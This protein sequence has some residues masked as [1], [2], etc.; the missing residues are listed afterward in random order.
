VLLTISHISTYRYDA[1][2]AYAV[3]RVRLWPSSC[4]V[5]TVRDW[6]LD[7]TGA[8]PELTY[9]DAFGNRTELLRSTP[10][11]REITIHAKG[12][13]DTRDTAGVFG[14][15]GGV[16]PL[17][18]HQRQT[19]LTEPGEAIRALVEPLSGMSNQIDL[20]HRLSGEIT[21]RVAY[22]PDSTDVATPAE[23]ALTS[24][25]GVC[26]DYAHIFIAAA[27]LLGRPA[28]YVSGYLLIEGRTEQTATHA[29]AEAYVD[30]LGW[31]GFDAANGVSP[32]EKY[33]RIACGLDY[34]HAAPITGLRRGA[35]T[36]T[37][38]VTL[39]VE[40]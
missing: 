23:T 5:Q 17:W 27:R 30:D 35:S 21:A 40:Q 10:D 11:T 36:E 37:L 7:V 9:S 3:Q 31:V 13:V 20:L 15:G 19:E 8:A 12:Q 38:A 2:V 18:I 39:N 16:P 14:Q 1:P 25:S 4:A 22:V 32:D 6:R 28:R 29:W 26:Q 33:V 24:G 34:S